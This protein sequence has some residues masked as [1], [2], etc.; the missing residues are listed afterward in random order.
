VNRCFISVALL[1]LSALSPAADEPDWALALPGW[2]YEFPRDH[3]AHPD[4]KTEWWYFTG[5]LTAE[6]GRE[7][8]FQ[9]TFF[10]Q[11]TR[12]GEV[13]LCAESVAGSVRRGG[14]FRWRPDRVD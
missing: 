1:A 9:L 3:F 14:L 11:G 7:F 6:D 2:K 8:G 10:R 12:R 13:P 4:F 5:N